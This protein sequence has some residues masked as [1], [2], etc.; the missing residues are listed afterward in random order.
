MTPTVNNDRR[1]INLDL[2]R[3]SYP[4]MAIASILHRI[5][6]IVLFLLLPVSLY[7][8]SLSLRSPQ[9]FDHLQ[10]LL[11]GCWAKVLL[12]AFGSAMIY[13]VL[14]GLRHIVMDMGWGESLE[15]GRRSA[16]SVIILAAV[17]ILAL[18]VWVC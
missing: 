8:L 7:F 1:P 15:S 10:Q 16:W 5:S 6:G 4:P 12:W 17:L 9:S 3:L 13:H 2:T 14:A 18:G 11:N